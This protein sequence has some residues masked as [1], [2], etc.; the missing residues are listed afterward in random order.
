[1]ILNLLYFLLFVIFI[2]ISSIHFYW[3]FG[4]KW[5]LSAVLPTKDAES[6]PT[7]P[8][9][10][11]TLI[12][13]LGLLMFGLFVGA[14][15]GFFSRLL[16]VL[17]VFFTKYGMWIISTIFFVRAIGEFHYVGFFKKIKHTNFAK[18]DTKLFSPLCLLISI[19]GVLIIFLA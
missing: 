19:L 3:V 8:G 18:W 15:G 2:G 5:G 13:A 9:V 10:I 17:P 14:F 4:G 7:N 16:E 12:V 1:M 6:E 11:L